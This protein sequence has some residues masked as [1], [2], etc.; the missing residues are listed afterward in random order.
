M[1]DGRCNTDVQDQDNEICSNFLLGKEY[2]V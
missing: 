1:E 2:E